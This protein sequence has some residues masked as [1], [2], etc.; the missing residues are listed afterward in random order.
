MSWKT[1]LPRGWA[2]IPLGHIVLPRETR[3]PRKDGTRTFRYVDI[4][5]LDNTS[6]RIVSPKDLPAGEAPSR[7]RVR[8]HS[9]DVL[10][11]LVRPYLKN[12]AIVPTGLDG[13]VAS[14]AF[15]SLR[16]AKGIDSRFLFYQVAQD[17][18]IHSIPTYG[19]S[20]P[21]ARDEEFLSLGVRVAPE[22]E[23]KRIAQKIE[24]LFSKL[25][26]GVAALER[27]R[28]SLKRYRASVLKA[29]VE[30]RLTARWREEN[31][32]IEPASKLLG[33]I[34]KERRRKWEEEQLRKFE[35]NG[36]NPP[37]GW[38]DKYKESPGPDASV[39]PS[40]PE[41]WLWSSIGQCFEVHVGATPSRREA[42]YWAGGIRWVSSGEV[43]FCRITKTKETISEIGLL[44]SSTQVNPS[45]SVLLGMIGEGKTR[46]QVAILDV[47]A[48]NNQNCAAIWVSKTPV[49][50]DFVYY[51]L[52]SRY[53]RTRR[54][55]SG[56]NQPALNKT[57]VERIPLPL[58][59]I[60]EQRAIVE[61]LDRS[62]SVM[63][64]I[65]RQASAS[66]LRADRLRQSILK[67][68]FEGRLVPQDPTDEPA[69]GLLD[70]IKAERSTTPRK[71]P[72]KT[73]GRKRMKTGAHKQLELPL[74]VKE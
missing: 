4:D 16:P 6:Q 44:H 21:A 39:L 14:T 59:P 66:L 55:G 51:W 7:A 65:E 22:A 70:R 74:E 64:E 47:D 35:K 57:R 67:Q 8:I 71:K 5:A 68:A 1:E 30:G 27:A 34:L 38:K 19:N 31:P 20:P 46:G 42:T 58:P 61:E 2:R 25:D 41:L 28:E 45:G 43:Q 15:F 40:V 33:R 73:V 60:D 12:I 23:Q 10:F 11:S 48:C 26:A 32:D 24:E 54:A 53:E 13:E 63:G 18:F 72:K 52:W 50:P 17:T 29:A 9:G 37:K 3:N 56:N 49:L 62:L 69:A 36:R